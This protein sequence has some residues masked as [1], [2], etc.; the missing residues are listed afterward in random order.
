MLQSSPNLKDSIFG[1]RGPLDEAKTERVK[2]NFARNFAKDYWTRQNSKVLNMNL[3][4]QLI[5]TQYLLYA[6]V[7]ATC[8]AILMRIFL[9]HGALASAWPDPIFA[10]GYYR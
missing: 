2:Q 10:Q 9:S 1:S 4:M 5:Y 3:S 7:L 6:I 8:S